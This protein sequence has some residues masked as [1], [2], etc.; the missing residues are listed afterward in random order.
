ML[1]GVQLFYVDDVTGRTACAFFS[2][3]NEE[4]IKAH[5]E[6]LKVFLGDRFKGYTKITIK[7]I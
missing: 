7:S 3:D 4:K 5:A 2:S 6:S 1:Y